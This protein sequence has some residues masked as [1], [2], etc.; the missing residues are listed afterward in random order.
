[1]TANILF[2][3]RYPD[4]FFGM[5]RGGYITFSPSPPPLTLQ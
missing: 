2:L 5:Q 3:P 4:F 1:M